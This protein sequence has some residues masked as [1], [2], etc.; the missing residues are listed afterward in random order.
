MNSFPWVRIKVWVRF[1]LGKL[2]T[3]WLGD[4]LT[5]N[6]VVYSVKLLF[7]RVHGKIA[8]TLFGWSACWHKNQAT[9]AVKR[10]HQP[11]TLSLPTS[12]CGCCLC[13]CCSCPEALVLISRNWDARSVGLQ[14]ILSVVVG[15][16]LQSNDRCDDSAPQH[17]LRL[18]APCYGS[19][20][21]VQPGPLRLRWENS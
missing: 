2:G 14:S 5:G 9:V 1:A 8:A 4:E 17:C 3:T 6:R 16:R 7:F 10:N 12:G 11:C 19:P 20:R 13:H 21:A 15:G 18:R